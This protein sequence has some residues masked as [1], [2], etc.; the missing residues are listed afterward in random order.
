MNWRKPFTTIRATRASSRHAADDIRSLVLLYGGLLKNSLEASNNSPTKPSEAL[1]LC[2][3]F[4]H[5]CTSA[6]LGVLR[7]NEM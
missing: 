7:K 1:P 4:T 2:T 6:A 5:P 3:K